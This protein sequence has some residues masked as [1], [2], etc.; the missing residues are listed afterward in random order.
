MWGGQC[1]QSTES[2]KVKMSS[3][4]C[5]VG[6]SNIGNQKQLLEILGV[7]PSE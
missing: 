2:D 5:G 6:E 1:F 7:V 3:F 4:I